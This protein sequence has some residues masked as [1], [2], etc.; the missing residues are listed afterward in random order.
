[1]LSMLTS[2]WSVCGLIFFSDSTSAF[3][4]SRSRLSLA[5]RFWNQV[6][7][8][9]LERPSCCAIWSRSAGERYFW[10]R[11]RF[12]SSAHSGDDGVVIPFRAA[13]EPET[14]S[15]TRGGQILATDDFFTEGLLRISSM[16]NGVSGLLELAGGGS[17]SRGA[18]LLSSPPDCNT[19]PAFM[20]LLEVI[21]VPKK[22]ISLSGEQKKKRKTSITTPTPP[23]KKAK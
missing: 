8:C 9:A 12:S 17:W 23:P 21:A 19:E 10:Y 18:R 22:K 16:L 5:R 1:M 11:K 6:M 4:S 2:F 3:I 14:F 13:L 15:R 7:T 20:S